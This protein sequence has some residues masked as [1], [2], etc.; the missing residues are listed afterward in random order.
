MNYKILALKWRPKIFKEIIGQEY[1]IKGITNSLSSGKIHNTY[2]LSGTRGVGKTTIARL[3]AKGLN[4]KNG[5]T[6]N[7]CGKCSNCIDINNGCSIDIIEIDAAS[8][9]KV[10][11]I[12]ELLEN[13]QYMPT[14]GRFKIY[15]I[16]EVHMLSRYSYNALLKT[17][18]EPPSY[19]K[20]ILATTEPQKLP[21]TIIS[22]CL[23]FHLQKLNI[24]QIYYHLLNI[25]NKEFIIFENYA[26]KLISNAANGSI[27]DAL[28]LVEQ[29]IVIG[30]GKIDIKVVNFMLGSTDIKQALTII[31]LIIDND[32]NSILKQINNFDIYGINWENLLIEILTLLY[33]ISIEQILPNQFKYKQDLNVV[34]RLQKIA[35]ILKSEN[36]HLYYKLFLTG[37]KELFFAPTPKIGIEMILINII[38][39]NLKF[40]IKKK[41]IY[42]YIKNKSCNK[43]IKNNLSSI[44]NNIFNKNSLKLN[45]LNKK[46][47]NKE[48]VNI[49]D[50]KEIIKDNINYTNHTFIPK[51]TNQ[52]L[53]AREILLHKK[54]SKKKKINF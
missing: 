41:L 11:D 51:K 42:D 33:N 19:T 46:Y 8:R 54:N 13:V 3:F 47:L 16:D 2:L 7:P 21:L 20:F 32:I 27:R 34:I 29:A 12:R 14:R 9:T 52:L 53:K 17:L 35:K 28:N 1:I 45:F 38:N 4:C 6:S 43:N 50:K 40:K 26:I 23:H 15:I 10:E 39:Y 44:Q 25:L 49:L 37:R 30:K 31:E 24:N 18:E 36:I 48:K 5:I 22:R